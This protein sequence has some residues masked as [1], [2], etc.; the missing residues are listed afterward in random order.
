L[1]VLWNLGEG[2]RSFRNLQML[3]GDISPSIL[4]SRLKDLREADILENSPVGYQLTARGQAL[5]QIIVPLGKWSAVWSEQVF[6]F[7]KPGMKE[8]MSAEP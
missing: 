5:R 8:K 3:C 6:Q 1:G 7:I 4:N 2:P